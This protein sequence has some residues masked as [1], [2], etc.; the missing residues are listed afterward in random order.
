MFD[1]KSFI[2]ILFL[3]YLTGETTTISVHEMVSPTTMKQVIMPEEIPWGGNRI[4]D[5]FLKIFCDLLGERNMKQFKNESE[6]EYWNFCREIEF[7]KRLSERKHRHVRIPVRLSRIINDDIS[8][9]CSSSKYKDEVSFRRNGLCS[10]KETLFENICKETCENIISCL[11]KILDKN[12]LAA[13][14]TVVLAGGFAECYI[15]QNMMREHLISRG[16][17]LI[18]PD[19]PELAVLI[20]AVYIGH[21]CSYE[22]NY[23]ET[24]D[25]PEI[26]NRLT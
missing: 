20:G 18:L 8:K 7:M 6:Y 10:I 3:V 16:K 24:E 14:E 25:I 23:E 26:N 9:V 1:F 22:E 2:I 4:N 15:M 12:D 19:H 13:V 11:Q 21:T 17:R 5:A